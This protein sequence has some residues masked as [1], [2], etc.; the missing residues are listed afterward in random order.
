MKTR[1]IS[2]RKKIDFGK[3]RCDDCNSKNLKERKDGL[4]D[5]KAEDL[6]RSSRWRKVRQQIIRRDK[7]CVLC[8]KSGYLEYKGLEVHHIVKRTDNLELAFDPSNLV[9]V[10]KMCHEKLEKLPPVK[11][12]EL[13]DYAPK[14]LEFYL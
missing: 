9:T 5:K 14:E 12:K 8:L 11:Q 3:T 13:L 7:C 4:K 1:C 6:I 2:C 10:C